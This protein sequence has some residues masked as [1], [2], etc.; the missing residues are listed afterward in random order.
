[1][2]LFLHICCSPCLAFPLEQLT[3]EGIE[4]TG[5]WYNPNIHPFTEY[6]KR[7]NSLKSF[8]QVKN[9]KVIYKDSYDLEDFFQK[10]LSQWFNNG[11]NL[12]K[13]CQYCYEMRLSGTASEAKKQGFENFST[14]LLV[15]PYQKHNLLKEVGEKV[16]KSFGVDFYYRDFRPGYYEGRK[17]A[18][19]MN[20]YVQKYC[21]CIFSEKERFKK[22]LN[23]AGKK[24]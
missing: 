14:T 17:M 10:V 2:K 13:R 7:L 24:V 18:K 15:S 21:G 4:L 6:Q 23:E 5:F 11:E 19:E 20:L 9:L 8:A 1:M 22:K 12:D 3:Q 16:G